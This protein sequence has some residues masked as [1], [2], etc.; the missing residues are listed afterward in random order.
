LGFLLNIVGGGL[1]Y[2]FK[3]NPMLSGKLIQTLKAL[4]D[5]EW[6]E[7]QLFLQSPYHNRGK[8]SEAV[9]SLFTFLQKNAANFDHIGLDKATVYAAVFSNA[10]V[11]PGKLE[12]LMGS[13]FQLL[14]MFIAVQQQGHPTWL[15]LAT[16]YRE[17]KLPHLAFQQHKIGITMLKD[18][19]PFAPDH[20]YLTWKL[21]EE[22]STHQSLFAQ[23]PHDFG[24][25]ETIEALDSFYLLQKLNYAC[26]FYMQGA[27]NDLSA[28]I[29]QSMSLQWLND[30]LPRLKD[31][32]LPQDP[33]IACYIAAYELMRNL[34]HPGQYL[35]V[36][37]EKAL[38]KYGEWLHIDTQMTLQSILRNYVLRHYIKGDD[39]YLPIAFR[40][41]RN[42]LEKGWLYFDGKLLPETMLNIVQLGLRNKEL[43]WVHDFLQAHQHRIMGNYPTEE[44]YQYNMAI[45]HFY[46]KDFGTASYLLNQDFQNPYYKVGARRLDLMILHEEKSDLLDSK[47]EAFKMF[48]FRFSK[49]QMTENIKQLNNHFVDFLRQIIHPTTLRNDSR[50]EKIRTKITQK[51]WVAERGW[52]LEKLEEMR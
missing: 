28:T 6:K 51:E 14:G 43:V 42:H 24:L 16:F 19:I 27:H 11:V 38:D 41:Y 25:P 45:F 12:K 21:K 18:S 47:I 48:I 36:Q 2:F 37:L 26:I 1:Q 5:S 29:E 22:V 15:A 39:N 17:R 33:A 35:S 50:I 9:L 3:H 8:E 49:K 10:P 13:L 34:K 23:K 7:L 40:T 30:S 46:S 4:N 31:S 32:N 52:L 44:T 20:H